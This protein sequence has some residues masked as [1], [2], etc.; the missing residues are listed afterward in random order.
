MIQILDALFREIKRNLPGWFGRKK[1]SRDL[2]KQIRGELAKL[3]VSADALEQT[4]RRT[5]SDEQNRSTEASLGAE[6]KDIITAKLGETESTKSKTE[7]ERSFKLHSDKLRELDTLLPRLKE[8][9]REFFEVS[10]SVKAV[11][12]QIDDFYHLR[13]R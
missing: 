4:V 6:A 1:R 11:F 12:L 3:K 5:T 13:N 2:I 10:T 9:V 7:T 8:Q